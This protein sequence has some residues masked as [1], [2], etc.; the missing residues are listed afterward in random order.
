MLIFCQRA[1]G[2]R[3]QPCHDQEEASHILLGGGMWGN[4]PW[5]LAV[6]ISISRIGTAKGAKI[7]QGVVMI[8]AVEVI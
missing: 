5:N 3:Y 8:V 6:F 4:I 7:A 2:D 1:G